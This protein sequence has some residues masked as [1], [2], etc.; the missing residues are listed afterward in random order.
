[1]PILHFVH[2][3]PEGMWWLI[4]VTYIIFIAYPAD[5]ICVFDNF[6]YPVSYPVS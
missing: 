1:M 4:V 3:D 5:S 2:V 6:K